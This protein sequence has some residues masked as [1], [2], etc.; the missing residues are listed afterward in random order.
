M[1]SQ[2]LNYWLCETQ[3]FV[4]NT[5]RV[6][7]DN[8]G[9]IFKFWPL[10]QKLVFFIWTPVQNKQAKAASW[11]RGIFSLI[12]GP[13]VCNIFCTPQVAL[14]PPGL[15]FDLFFQKL[16]PPRVSIL[17]LHLIAYLQMAFGATI[18]WFDFLRFCPPSRFFGGKVKWGIFNTDK[19]VTSDLTCSINLF[20]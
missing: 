5:S 7:T 12:I 4:L 10:G 14:W 8:P 16:S 2:R 13:N 19:N 1:T 9:K 17:Q 11:S 20:I 15:I 18:Q 6:R 3:N